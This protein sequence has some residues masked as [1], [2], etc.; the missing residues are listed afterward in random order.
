MSPRAR[1]RLSKEEELARALA[2][3]LGTVDRAIREL[4]ARATAGGGAQRKRRAKHR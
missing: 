2:A 1:E 3:V 4:E